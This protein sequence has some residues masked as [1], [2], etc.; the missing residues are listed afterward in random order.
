MS[1]VLDAVLHKTVLMGLDRAPAGRQTGLPAE[2]ARQVDPLL[3]QMQQ[4]AALWQAVAITDLCQRAGHVPSEV[5]AVDAAAA[6]ER[7][8]PQA[9]ESVLQLILRGFHSELLTT[10]LHLAEKHRMRLPHACLPDLLDLGLQKRNVRDALMP[11]LDRRG[12]WLVAQNP[13][14]GKVYGVA[15]DD[16]HTQWSLGNLTERVHA[17][18]KMRQVDPA[19][20]LAALQADWPNE[21]AEH[22][23][24]LLPCLAVGLSLHD[25]AFLEQALDDKRKEVRQAAQ[26]ML[27]TLPASQLV[28]RCKARLMP[29]L[30]YKKKMLT[31][32]TLNVALPADCEKAAQRDG[33]GM[34]TYPGLGQKA[35][36]LLDLVRV[37]PVE[38]WTMS[39]DLQP[40]EVIKLFS[41]QEFKQAL[42]PGLIQ[43]IV[44]AA[45]CQPGESATEWYSVLLTNAVD[46]K[47][48]T[49]QGSK[50]M[51]G[52]GHLSATVQ[53]TMVQSWLAHTDP[54]WCAGN[55][56]IEWCQQAARAATK[57]WSVDLSKSI[58]N[59]I[60]QG[61]LASP[62][63]HW[64]LRAALPGFAAVL[65]A[66]ESDYFEL[67]WPQPDWP[68]WPHWRKPIDDVLDTLRFRH[69]MERSFLETSL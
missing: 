34:Q 17:L 45:E 12:Q 28:S 38:H 36:W 10:W 33:V 50:I 67:H 14:W 56:I 21:P 16:L 44:R 60:Q 49:E 30:D 53:E 69:T 26:Q 5:N 35:G 39:L 3:Q 63:N 13:A 43:A 42:L 23:A 65:N 66:G 1:L 64:T 55:P 22:R 54:N 46:G 57:A 31:G 32:P 59:R 61:M 9:A 68:H 41:Q 29:L 6:D 24:S 27:A 51:T 8:C 15:G 62:E 11:L 47:L 40:D 4:E 37:M 18:R 2:I 7:S 20:T 52:F 19:A 48:G 58:L 25:E